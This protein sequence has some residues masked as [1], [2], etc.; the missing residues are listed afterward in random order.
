MAPVD[1]LSNPTNPVVVT[2]TPSTA[3]IAPQTVTVGSEPTGADRFTRSPLSAPGG[4]RA[5]RTGITGR[6]ID[7]SSQIRTVAG[8]GSFPLSGH[9]ERLDENGFS[10]DV[11]GMNRAYFG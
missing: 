11:A 2:G 8:V 4:N 6:N 3:P 1:K 7:P 5:F 9:F 10:S